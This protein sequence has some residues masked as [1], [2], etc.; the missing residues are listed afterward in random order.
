MPPPDPTQDFLKRRGVRPDLATGG[1]A[2]LIDRWAEVVGQLR[3]G[4]SLTLDDYLNDM[5]VRQLIEETLPHASV[6]AHK[7]ATVR[8]FTLDE[9]A[10]SVLVLTPR[11]LWGPKVE[12][13]KGWTP[14]Q[15][16]W[17]YAVPRNPGP[18]LKADLAKG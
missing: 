8:L 12:A 9:E 7:Q 4:Y 16:W 11:C 10:Q 18:Q 17:Y 15:N 6:R 1:L 5:D 3:A 2:G 13:A 14:E